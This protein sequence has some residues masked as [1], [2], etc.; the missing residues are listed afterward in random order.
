MVQEGL[1]VCSNP[2]VVHP[3]VRF[4]MLD[5]LIQLSKR[6][7]NPGPALVAQKSVQLGFDRLPW[8]RQLD[9]ATQ[10]RIVMTVLVAI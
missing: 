8:Q 4:P 1:N 2:C 10:A 6:E 3:V 5:S 9:L 7:A